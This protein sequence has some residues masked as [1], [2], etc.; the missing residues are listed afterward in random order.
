MRRSSPVTSF[1]CSLHIFAGGSSLRIQSLSPAWPT[2]GTCSNCRS[3]G[4]NLLLTRPEAR[5]SCPFLRNKRW[6]D[7]ATNPSQDGLPLRL[8][9][10]KQRDRV[11]ALDRLQVGSRKP[12]LGHAD[13]GRADGHERVVAAEHDLRRGDE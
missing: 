11:I 5:S 4:S 10:R 2:R 8:Q 3:R 6:I 13:G 7:S 9:A 12:E 1:S